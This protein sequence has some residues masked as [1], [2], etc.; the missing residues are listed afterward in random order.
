MIKT[1]KLKIMLVWMLLIAMM[2]SS[3]TFAADTS[4]A[5]GT[6]YGASMGAF[7]GDYYGRE[8]ANANRVNNYLNDLL[9]DAQIVGKF[10]LSR[11]TASFQNAFIIA[12]R[13]AF[14]T[15]YQAGYREVAMSKVLAPVEAAYGHGQSLGTIQGQTEATLDFIQ[16]RKNDWAVSYN[17]LIAKSPLL[18]RYNLIKETM[19]YRT[20]FSN[21]YK[22]GFMT[23]YITTFQEQNVTVETANKEVKQVAMREDSITF[24]DGVVSLMLHFPAATLYEPTNFTAFTTQNS[25]NYRN[26]SSH[27]TPVTSKYTVSVLNSRGSVTLK[28]P[29]T[30][31]FEY[32]GSER[33]GIYQWIGN[34]WVYQFT[35][36]TD[37]SLFITIPAGTYAGGEYAIFIDEKYKNVS[38][39]TFNWAYK[40]I[41]TLMRRGIVTDAAPFKPNDKITRGT[42][43]LMVYNTRAG[44]DPL[45]T[46]TRV[47]NDFDSL[48]WYKEAAKYMVNKGYMKLDASGNFN[49]NGL[50][51]YAD[52]EHMLSVMYTR[53]FKWTEISDRMLTEKFTRSAGATNL[54][55]NVTKAETA[56]MLIS[57]FK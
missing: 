30:L 35:T 16:G 24:D 13:D 39:I 6:T 7:D 23:A 37:G 52:V 4:V 18:V 27:M 3:L 34:K 43:A 53:S 50:V 46:A 55:A 51:T 56:F 31:S 44:V 19:G 38:D 32:Y 22:E 26:Y 10:F 25:F 57:V 42:F 20:A 8:A 47:I 14:Q 49:M 9:T 48:S 29:I 28:K 41:Y 17:A 36:I 45:G 33:A 40:E 11:D 54:N 21:G 5:D 15:A 12:Y 2:S 1:N